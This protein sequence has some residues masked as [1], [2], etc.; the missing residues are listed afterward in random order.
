MIE[1][2]EAVQKNA[3]LT[4]GMVGGG[5]GSFIGD[6]HRKALAFDRSATLTAG[7]FSHRQEASRAT[8]LALGLNESRLYNDPADMAAG[9]ARR[10][11][12]IDFV[13]IVTPNSDHYRIAKAFLLAGIP[14]VCEKP[15]TFETAEAEELD[16][17]ARSK[18]LLFCVTYAY[19]GYPAV[20]QAKAMV[21]SGAL[22]ELRFV[23]AEYPQEW[24]A[25]P[26]ESTGQKQAAWRSDP[27]LAGKSNC[28]GDI[29]SHIE[30]LV[31]YVTGLRIARLCAR[32]D[33][34]V[35]GRVLDDNSTVMVDYHGGAKGLYWSSQIAVGHDNGLKLRVYGA[36]GSLEWSQ[37]TPNTFHFRPIDRPA[38]T[39]SRGRDAFS[40]HAQSYS[41]IPSG[42]PEGYNEAFA[43]LYATFCRALAAVKAGQKP[44]PDDLDFPTAREGLDGVRYIGKCVESSDAGSVW[45]SLT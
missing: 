14:V 18:N 35:P 33:R 26:L 36:K 23:N 12:K 45:V 20:K 6:V 43:N 39:W 7:C 34:M 3:G 25:G 24:L 17:L 4:Y 10:Q 32:L 40:P 2:V 5:Q 8:G 27:K 13:V 28:T 22:G 11:D 37:E 41:R 16:A 30:H 31:S 9:E 44:Q 19:S 1:A 15:L 29:G 38:E 42:H 21:A